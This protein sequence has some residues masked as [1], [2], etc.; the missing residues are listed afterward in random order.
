ML[1][2]IIGE[3]AY[4]TRQEIARISKG[5]NGEIVRVSGEDLTAGQLADLVAGSSLFASDQLAIIRDLSSNSS[6]WQEFEKWIPRIAESTVVILVEQSVDKRTKTY[7][8]LKKSGTIIEAA[9]WPERDYRLAEAW[10]D[11]MANESGILIA[12]EQLADMVRRATHTGSGGKA[13]IDQMELWS[14]IT[15]LQGAE[16][17]TRDMI[18]TVMPPDMNENIF[19][20]F[21]TALQGD[22]SRLSEMLSNLK[23][24]EDPYK[25]FGL[26]ANQWFQLVSLSVSTA[27]PSQVAGQLGMHPFPLQKMATYRTKFSRRELS[28]LSTLLARLDYESKTSSAEPWYAVE[29]FLLAIVATK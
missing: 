3:N 11:K 12:R 6:L 23:A 21:V 9:H 26:L 7:K 1:Y 16:R 8:A 13:Y 4:R 14:A 17:V 2:L 5:F 18:D 28:R 24:T 10:L 19:E 27:P 29:R 20:L 25:T 15:A 22:S